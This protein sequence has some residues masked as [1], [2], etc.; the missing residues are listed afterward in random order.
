MLPL[1]RRGIAIHHHGLLPII[2]ELVEL[3]FQEDLVKAIF[4]TETFAI[5]LNMPP[6]MVVFTSVRK[7]D[8]DS[9]RY[10]DP[11]E[12]ILM[13]GKAGRHDK[14]EYGICIIMTDNQSQDEKQIQSFKR[15]ELNHEIQQLETKLSDLRGH[16]ACLINTGD[17]LIVSEWI[18]DGI[19][20]NLDYHQIA[21]L[22]SCFILGD[23]STEQ[24]HVTSELAM[25]LQQL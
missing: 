18:F 15:K 6:K 12:Y 20:D 10:I 5:G 1:L 13:S 16:I 23:K 4:A 25:P 21:A 11:C 9:H 2:K 22:A 8:G 24:I 17:G 14:D 3:M 7:G 19:L